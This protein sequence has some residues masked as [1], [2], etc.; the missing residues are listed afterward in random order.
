MPSW[1]GAHL[2]EK[3]QGQL[4]LYPRDIQWSDPSSIY[5]ELC[6]ISNF[7][8]SAQVLSLS[9]ET[10]IFARIHVLWLVTLIHH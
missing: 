5:I 3:A 1:S 7:R 8:S 9:W 6:E 2:K 10:N 4:Y